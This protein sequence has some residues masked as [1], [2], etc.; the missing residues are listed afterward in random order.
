MAWM[1]IYGSVR[2]ISREDLKYLQSRSVVSMTLGLPMV[3]SKRDALAVPLPA[4]LDDADLSTIPGQDAAESQ[5]VTTQTEFYVQSLRLYEITEEVLTTMYASEGRITPMKT[6]NL[7]PIERVNHVDFNT[8][9]KLEASLQR[10]HA[11]LPCKL[12]VREN[13]A[14]DMLDPVFSRQANLL[15]LR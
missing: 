3:I 14:K 12:K 1:Y 8:V 15:R 6:E 7:L 2:E 11:S 4:C 10:W 9:L 13:I 5:E